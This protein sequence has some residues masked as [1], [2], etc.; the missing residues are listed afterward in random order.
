[1]LLTP[2]L[3]VDLAVKRRDVGCANMFGSDPA[4][5]PDQKCDR[6]SENPSIKF[7]CFSIAHHN[8][9]IHSEALVEVAY[10]FR[11]IIHGNADDLQTLVGILIL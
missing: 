5:P 2:Q 6:Q 4:I 3:R 9:V 7:T 10:R 1:M 11:F 8:R